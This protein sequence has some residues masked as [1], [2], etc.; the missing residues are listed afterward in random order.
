M[1][2]TICALVSDFHRGTLCWCPV[3]RTASLVSFH[4]GIYR[5]IRPQRCPFDEEVQYEAQ[6]DR[7]RHSKFVGLREDKNAKSVIKEHGDEA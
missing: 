2:R 3:Q 1:A 7:L 4:Q 6:V 5:T